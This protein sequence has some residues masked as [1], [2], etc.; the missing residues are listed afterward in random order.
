[1]KLKGTF[2]WLAV[3][4]V[5][6]VL[7]ASAQADVIYLV[8]V[9]DA[10]GSPT[11]AGWNTVSLIQAGIPANSAADQTLTAVNGVDTIG[12]TDMAVSSSDRGFSSSN[13]IDIAPDWV[14]E[15]AAND[16]EWLFDN[17][18][19]GTVQLS[20]NLSGLDTT[21]GVTYTVEIWSARA[22]NSSSFV[23]VTIDGAFS[24]GGLSNDFNWGNE[25]LTGKDANGT[26]DVLTWSNLAASDGDLTVNI[27]GTDRLGVNAMRITQIPEPATMALLSLGGLAVL[28]RRR[29]A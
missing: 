28:K 13:S 2:G 27:V 10:G 6:C 23:D 3:V 12:L 14:T 17:N 1:M 16:F 18:G 22:N 25:G 8:D 9:G 19:D 26:A 21:P 24:D 20:F 29:S 15:D 7:A 4:A 5:T 11:E